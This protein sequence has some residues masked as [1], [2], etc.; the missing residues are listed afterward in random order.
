LADESFRS[1]DHNSTSRDDDED[2]E[3]E[4][5]FSEDDG[6]ANDPLAVI[7]DA[8]QYAKLGVD[9]LA[10]VQTGLANLVMGTPVD[11]EATVP[12][13]D[14]KATAHNRTIA[15][16]VKIYSSAAATL[17]TK[18]TTTSASKARVLQNPTM[19][20]PGCSGRMDEGVGFDGMMAASNVYNALSKGLRDEARAG[21]SGLGTSVGIDQKEYFSEADGDIPMLPANIGGPRTRSKVSPTDEEGTGDIPMLSATALTRPEVSPVDEEA[22]GDI[23]MFSATVFVPKKALQDVASAEAPGNIPMLY[24]TARVP[25]TRKVIQTK[26]KATSVSALKHPVKPATATSP[27]PNISIADQA[28]VGG[29]WSIERELSKREQ[30]RKSGGPMGA[31]ERIASMNSRGGDA[32]VQAH[33]ASDTQSHSNNPQGASKSSQT[34]NSKSLKQRST[35]SEMTTAGTEKS[36]EEPPY[37]RQ[38]NNTVLDL[39]SDPIPSMEDE[40]PSLRRSSARTPPN[41]Q[42]RSPPATVVE[43]PPSL[44]RSVESRYVG[45]ARQNEPPSNDT[46]DESHSTNSLMKGLDNLVKELEASTP[47][48]LLGAK[49][50]LADER[51]EAKQR[52]SSD[53][54][55]ISDGKPILVESIDNDFGI[56]IGDSM[57][58]LLNEDA[59]TSWASRVDEA[60]WRCRI[61]RRSLDSKYNEAKS[62][63]LIGTPSRGRTS[64]PVDV[65]DARVVGGVESVTMTQGAAQEH[66]KYDDFDDALMLYEDI[67][68]SYYRYFDEVLKMGDRQAALQHVTD[69][70]SDFKPYIGAALHNIGIGKKQNNVLIVRV[71]EVSD[72]HVYA[73]SD[74]MFL[75]R[76]L[77]CCR[78]IMRKRSLTLSVHL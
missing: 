55:A 48:R 67:I 78:D 6:K 44:S 43:E 19:G 63:K 70:V 58:S 20:I 27:P 24:A 2:E 9:A 77:A 8:Q 25:K 1:S 33:A 71:D 73:H 54:E 4:I 41:K 42:N 35:G 61:M 56:P 18:T 26:H 52:V 22:A 40:P 53:P 17:R 37:M 38:V 51:P 50:G 46:D 36:L 5:V 65:D 66:L 68:F 14:A 45:V 72:G 64:V 49:P 16:P 34:R 7:L 10:S 62:N 29:S 59:E 75:V 32:P 69:S 21:I 3:E 28:E 60:V 11:E 30:L 39:C 74:P 15:S 47:T 57:L 13:V 12:S 31:A 76:K 23:P